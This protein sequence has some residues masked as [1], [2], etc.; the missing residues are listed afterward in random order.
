[1]ECIGL[2]IVFIVMTIV[3]PFAQMLFGKGPNSWRR[4][5][6]LDLAALLVIV[7]GFAGALAIVRWLDLASALCLLTIVLPLS[8]SFAW[9]CRYVLED[10]TSGRRK[11]TRRQADLSFLQDAAPPADDVVKA[12]TAGERPDGA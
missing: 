12:Q 7:A 6:R 11:R 5:L 9:L 2:V 10:V 3:I 1:M 8:L 4:L